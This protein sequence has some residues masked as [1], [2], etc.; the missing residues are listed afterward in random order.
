MP[1]FLTRKYSDIMFFEMP[2]NKLKNIGIY[3]SISR[4]KKNNYS[5]VVMEMLKETL[6]GIE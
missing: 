2:N 4:I 1:R 6:Q 3:F 5:R